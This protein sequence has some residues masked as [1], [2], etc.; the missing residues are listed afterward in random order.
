[1]LHATILASVLRYCSTDSIPGLLPDECLVVGDVQ[2]ALVAVDLVRAVL[3]I[4]ECGLDLLLRLVVAVQDQGED[5]LRTIISAIVV[6]RL[7]P[8]STCALAVAA[9]LAALRFRFVCCHLLVH[10]L[11]FGL[12]LSAVVCCSC[13]DTGMNFVKLKESDTLRLTERVD[14]RCSARFEFIC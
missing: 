8:C 9:N 2:V 10:L 6:A 4:D 5:A 14:E 1:M 3:L 13:C 12:G 11:P 7:R